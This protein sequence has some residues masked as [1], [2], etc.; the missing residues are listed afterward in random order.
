[1]FNV[2]DYDNQ[3]DTGMARYLDYT[4]LANKVKNSKSLSVLVFL[5]LE[6]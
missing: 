6:S 1:M 2:N 5:I 4:R 3:G